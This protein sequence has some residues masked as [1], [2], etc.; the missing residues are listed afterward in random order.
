MDYIFPEKEYISAFNNGK[1][2]K[3]FK[4]AIPDLYSPI[5]KEALFLHGCIF[6]GHFDNCTINP[7]ARPES[8]NPFG[9]TFADLNN[10][11]ETKKAALITNNPNDISEVITWWECRYKALKDE[12][13]IDFLSNY[14]VPH[15]LY[16]L[17]PR[18]CVRGA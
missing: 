1:G 12:R 7:L 11:F 13:K 2:Q 15:P 17:K 18:T 10:E 16:R 3:Y 6:H 8:L 14:Y 4:E 9:K 5:T